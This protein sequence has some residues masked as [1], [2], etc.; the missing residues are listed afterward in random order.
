MSGIM[1]NLLIVILACGVSAFASFICAHFCAFFLHVLLVVVLVC[2]RK[3]RFNREIERY[4]STKFHFIAILI[5]IG[6]VG[7]FLSRLLDKKEIYVNLASFFVNAS[8]LSIT[9]YSVE[10]KLIGYYSLHN[11]IN[12]TTSDND[13]PPER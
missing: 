7:I 3:P 2:I 12:D 9:L 1:K 13:S 6:A 10:E 5:A 4:G 11:P 8:L